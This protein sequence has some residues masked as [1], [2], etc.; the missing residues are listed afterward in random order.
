MAEGPE[1]LGFNPPQ[2]SIA[3]VVP[4]EAPPME[5]FLLR[6]KP[7]TYD[8]PAPV[9]PPVEDLLADILATIEMESRMR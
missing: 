8:L 2:V 9:V 4:V 1:T 7:V 5:T 3:P 6:A